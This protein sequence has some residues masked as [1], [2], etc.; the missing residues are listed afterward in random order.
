ML[1]VS[2]RYQNYQNGA[3]SNQL[4][5]AGKG[6]SVI[7]VTV[8]Q[9]ICGREM[10]S[11]HKNLP[12]KGLVGRCLSVWGPLPCWFFLFGVLKQ[13]C[14]FGIWSNIQCITHVSALHTTRSP[15]PPPCYTL[16]KYID[17]YVHVLIH[18]GKGGRWGRWTSDKVR[19]AVF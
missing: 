1:V 17:L 8:N 14:R 11:F 4:A 12:V 3:V 5:C 9:L 19:G 16:Y 6:G 13:F 10:S 2:E 7:G 15:P 18:T